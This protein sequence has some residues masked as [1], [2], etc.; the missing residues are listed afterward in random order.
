M[1]RGSA[2]YILSSPRPQRSNVLYNYSHSM[3]SMRSFINMRKTIK[4]K[5]KSE[6]DMFSHINVST[7]IKTYNSYII[8]LF[9][10]IYIFSTEQTCH[11]AL[12]CSRSNVQIRVERSIYCRNTQSTNWYCMASQ[13]IFRNTRSTN[14][15]FC[16]ANQYHFLSRH[17]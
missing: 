15:F 8:K 9:I 14:F 16:T 13:S 17:M 1:F 5:T 12:C 11:S 4:S 3:R 7:E 10:F 6:V 2:F